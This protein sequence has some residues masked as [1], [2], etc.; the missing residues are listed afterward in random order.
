MI[1]LDLIVCN[2][3]GFLHN[4]GRMTVAFS[5]AHDNFIVVGSQSLLED[6]RFADWKE[7]KK[8]SVGLNV[9]NQKPSILYYLQYFIRKFLTFEI[10][11]N[12]HVEKSLW[13][14][15]SSNGNLEVM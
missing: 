5:H 9:E 13:G 15:G 2:R 4:D 12:E 6:N 8:N 11:G 1:I 10:R 14:M 3:I 7:T